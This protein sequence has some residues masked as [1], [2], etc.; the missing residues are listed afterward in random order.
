MA[1]KKC[2]ICNSAFS[3][4][5]DAKTCSARCRKRL[6]L[7]RQGLQSQTLQEVTDYGLQVPG[8]PQPSYPGLKKALATI[9]FGFF[10][11]LALLLSSGGNS[12]QAATSS[13]INFQARLL[14]DSG[15]LVADGNYHIEFK[16]YDHI[17][18]GGQ[19]QGTCSG[20]CLWIETRDNSPTD[21]R[22]RVVNGYFSV[23]LGSVSALPSINWNQEL[24]LTM[25]IGGSGGSPAWESSEMTNSRNSIQL[26][27][28]P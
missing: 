5:A 14:T 1:A 11:L 10:G 15:A 22:V 6:Q 18:S 4:R 21:D 24:F 8:K 26:N 13:Y 23:S 7:V 20:N 3:G 19:A 12:V 25:R 17:S 16:I 9:A 28:L 2:L 27:S